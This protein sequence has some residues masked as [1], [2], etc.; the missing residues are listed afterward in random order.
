M[1]T[2]TY[3]NLSQ[4]T[5]G[6]LVYFRS[7]D[8]EQMN[9]H[10]LLWS[11]PDEMLYHLSQGKYIRIIDKTTSKRGGKIKRIFIPTINDLL[12]N[13]YF[14][15]LAK[16]KNLVNHYLYALETMRK[17]KS[18]LTKFLYWREIIFNPV[19]IIGEDIIVDKE[20]N[21]LRPKKYLKLLEEGDQNVI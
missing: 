20:P 5:N 1:K 7:T 19:N 15:I 10:R 8:I 6:R 17:D 21:P 16:N 11:I 4:N 2:I 13:L 12:N 9:W 3:H 18:L 14:D